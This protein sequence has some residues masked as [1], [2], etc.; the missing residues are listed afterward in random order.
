MLPILNESLAKR[1]V[2]LKSINPGEVEVAT[3]SASLIMNLQEGIDK[4]LA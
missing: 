2:D 4:E 1:S 3:G